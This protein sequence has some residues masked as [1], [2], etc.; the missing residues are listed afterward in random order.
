MLFR[1]THTRRVHFTT[2]LSLG[3]KIPKGGLHVWKGQDTGGK[4]SHNLLS[5]KSPADDV[6]T[7]KI[8]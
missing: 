7:Y 8:T 2:V 4:A 3:G 1:S 6:Q 5:H